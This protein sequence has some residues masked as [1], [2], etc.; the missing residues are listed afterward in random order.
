MPCPLTP[1]T[2][3]PAGGNATAPFRIDVSARDGN[4]A[5]VTFTIQDESLTDCPVAVKT[6]DN[7]K[8]V[9]VPTCLLFD[10]N[11]HDRL[12]ATTPHSAIRFVP[13]QRLV[14]AV[15]RMT[16]GSGDGGSALD[17]AETLSLGPM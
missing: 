2:P 15:R 11:V 17:K 9:A 1:A 5:R 7:N 12:G 10:G 16:G 8:C 13:G 6:H 3:A 14:G 4:H